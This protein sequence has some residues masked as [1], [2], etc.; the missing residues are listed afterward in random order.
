MT[1]M[2]FWSIKLICSGRQII[3]STRSHVKINVLTR[4]GIELHGRERK[5]RICQYSNPQRDTG[6]EC[7][8]F[9]GSLANLVYKQLTIARPRHMI[10]VLLITRKHVLKRTSSNHQGRFVK[11][12]STTSLLNRWFSLSENVNELYSRIVSLG[13]T[14]SFLINFLPV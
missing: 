4:S 12:T 9:D 2:R 6:K 10:I 11:P 1:R 5:K 3:W 7:K 14:C 8:I 13:L